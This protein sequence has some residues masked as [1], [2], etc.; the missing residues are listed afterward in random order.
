LDGGFKGE[1]IMMNKVISYFKKKDLD[2]DLYET[3]VI[4]KCRTNIRKD[5]PIE[6]RYGYIEGAGQLCHKCYQKIKE[7]S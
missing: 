3:C 7:Q 5:Q 4:C 2:D 6:Q 1:M